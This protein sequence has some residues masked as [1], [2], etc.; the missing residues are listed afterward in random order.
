MRTAGSF[1]LL[2]PSF[3]HLSLSIRNTFQSSLSPN[4]TVGSF[5]HGAI[6]ACEYGLPCISG[7]PGVTD[8]I[9]DGDLL[10]VDGT[11]GIVKIV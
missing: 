10:V 7:L 5:Q 11:N 2:W 9:K 1:L 4:G 6:I 3:R 8:T